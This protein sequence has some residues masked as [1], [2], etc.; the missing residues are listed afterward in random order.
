VA[1][2]IQF[3][4]DTIAAQRIKP[5]RASRALAHLSAAMHLAALSG[6]SGR[7]DVVAGAASVVARCLHPEAAERLDALVARLADTRS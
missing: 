6:E 4:L 3:E 5:P 2:W 1:P 7:D